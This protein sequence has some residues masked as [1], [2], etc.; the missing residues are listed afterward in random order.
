MDEDEEEDEDEDDSAVPFPRSI[1]PLPRSGRDKVG[2]KVG[3]KVEDKLGNWPMGAGE[4]AMSQRCRAWL[5]GGRLRMTK[6]GGTLA[7]A[8]SRRAAFSGRARVS[9]AVRAFKSAGPRTAVF[10]SCSAQVAQKAA[11]SSGGER[12]KSVAA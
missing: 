6:S 12:S 3:D 9:I 4:V 1:A 8:C 2:D 7:R 11:K 5:R 10:L